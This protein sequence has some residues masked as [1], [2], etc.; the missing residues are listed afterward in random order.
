MNTEEFIEKAKII[1]G[2]KYDYSKTE[3]NGCFEKVCIICPEHGEFWQS[4]NN[5]LNG[6][7]CS[8]CSKYSN[9]YNTKEWVKKAKEIHGD[10]YDYSKVE[11]KSAKKNVI[12]IC[13]EHG[14]FSIR[15]DN[16]NNG[17]GCPICRYIKSS[18]A[19]R[20]NVDTFISECKKIHGN[21]YDYSKIEYKNNKTKVCIICSEHGEFWQTPDNHLKGKGC[22]KCSQ[23]KLEEKTK[24]FLIEN[25]VIFE[26]QKTFD[27]LLFKK[28]MKLDFYLPTYK[29]A[30]ECQGI[31]HFKPFEYFG[32][33]DG[34]NYNIEKDNKKSVLCAE[35]G[36]KLFYFSNENYNKLLGKKV[37]HDLNK[38][39]KEIK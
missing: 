25:N 3:Y 7:G 5:H 12:V 14:E 9:H 39:L 24:E 22:P 36:V 30:I 32:G 17:Q 11:Y 35:N 28:P 13:P 34:L 19:I 31:Q 1:H 6:S 23:S 37:Y 15:P 20:K 8:K 21:K 33:E 2:D 27:W 18:S 4:P 10:K 38:L 29:V 26:E 16:H